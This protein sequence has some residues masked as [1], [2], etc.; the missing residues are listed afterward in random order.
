MNQN[1]LDGVVAIEAKA[2]EIVDG[3]K[4]RASEMDEK[5]KADLDAL[6]QELDQK[7]EQETAAYAQEVEGKRA[8][9]LAELDQ[10]L[11]AAMTA[12]D[13]VKGE[14]VASLAAEVAKL[15]E[16]RTHGN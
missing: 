9:A 15:L 11:D 10:Q 5:V 13:A 2:A 16:Q 6:A 3:A 4:K 7:A 1:V 8:A 12:L 14:P